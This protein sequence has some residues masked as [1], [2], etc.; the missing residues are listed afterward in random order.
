GLARSLFTESA[1]VG[2][3]EVDQASGPS[4]RRQVPMSHAQQIE[5]F[6][7]ACEPG[8]EQAQPV[9]LSWIDPLDGGRLW[10]ELWS[11]REFVDELLSQGF[12]VR[13]VQEDETAS[14]LCVRILHR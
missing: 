12:E 6:S 5:R 13:C 14:S 8:A 7:P 2:P 11:S 1:Q 10:V 4:E 3:V 9:L